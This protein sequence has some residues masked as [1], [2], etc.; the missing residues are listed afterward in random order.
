MNKSI[1]PFALIFLVWSIALAVFG[2]AKPL[3]NTNIHSSNDHHVHELPKYSLAYVSPSVL[4]KRQIPTG[5]DLE[6]RLEFV[7]GTDNV[8]VVDQQKNKIVFDARYD[9]QEPDVTSRKVVY[10][11]AYSTTAN[12]K[13][14]A[15]LRSLGAIK[16]YYECE[17]SD[18]ALCNKAQQAF[19]N[20][21]NYISKVISTKRP[22]VVRAAFVS[23]C[24]SVGKCDD[25]TLGHASASRYWSTRDGFEGNSN[26]W[27]PQALVKQLSDTDLIWEGED[28]TIKFNSD[29]PNRQ[30]YKRQ[31]L[32]RFWFKDD[33]KPIQPPQFDFEYVALHELMHGLGLM[34]LWTTEM[35]KFTNAKK[36][37]TPS[38]EISIHNY[39]NGTKEQVFSGFR[40]PHIYDR[41]IVNAKTGQPVFKSFQVLSQNKLT[42]DMPMKKF[43][44][45]LHSKEVHQ[46][47]S[48]MYQ[49]TTTPDAIEIRL[50]KLTDNQARAFKKA[51]VSMSSDPMSIKLHTRYKEFRE[52]STLSHFDQD[53]YKGQADFL[54]RPEAQS[55]VRLLGITPKDKFPVGPGTMRLLQAIGYEL[56]EEPLPKVG[57]GDQMSSS[58]MQQPSYVLVTVLIVLTTLYM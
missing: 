39:A 19:E 8:P 25:D 28:I 21:V 42:H 30:E 54:M 13:S 29:V 23:F 35:T 12:I 24:Q 32:R 5:D 58:S 15:Q 37:L 49:M 34:T 33:K 14:S 55:G 47:T 3:T 38:F 27:Y 48:S 9:M 31:N 26:F 10:S 1:V 57:A 40:P 51:G 17:I 52:G 43:E 11:S 6:S 44:E 16:L 4:S 36:I 53:A 45:V 50:P 41:F 22:I 2:S 7:N 20:A 46:E 56:N 18:K